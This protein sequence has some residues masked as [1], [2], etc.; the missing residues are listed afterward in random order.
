MYY[1]SPEPLTI[2]IRKCFVS[3]IR[4]IHYYTD[5]L[6]AVSEQKPEALDRITYFENTTSLDLTEEEKASDEPRKE[7]ELEPLGTIGFKN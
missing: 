7:E 2:K 6:S 5:H 1:D 4:C 3:L